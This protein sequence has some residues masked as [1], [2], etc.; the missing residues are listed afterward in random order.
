MSK[1]ILISPDVKNWSKIYVF[2]HQYFTQIGLSHKNVF[3]I[4]I[5]SEEIFSNVLRHSRATADE[6]IIISVNYEPL[7]KTASV[8]FKYGGVEF[9]PLK[10]ELP[11][12]SLPPG[13]RKPGGLGLLIVKNFTDDIVYTYSSG[14]NILKIFKKIVDF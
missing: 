8:V 1:N 2:I 13:R 5:S 14:K 4:L 11:D 12:V 6:K 10:T 3:G 9:D 7:A